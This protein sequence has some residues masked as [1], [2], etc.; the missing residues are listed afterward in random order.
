MKE[1]RAR[2]CKALFERLVETDGQWGNT[3]SW[4]T[5]CVAWVSIEPERGTEQS[6]QNEKESVT[7]HIVRGDYMDL[8]DVVATMRMVFSPRMDYSVIPSDAGV[9]QILTVMPSLNDRRDVV[10]RVAKEGRP[11][12]SL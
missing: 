11:Y 1:A 12:G 3:K 8:K 4:I 7:T 6:V 2:P 5:H 9:Y 10:I